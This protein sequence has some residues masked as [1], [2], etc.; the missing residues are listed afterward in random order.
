MRLFLSILFTALALSASAQTT[1]DV[2]LPVKSDSGPLTPVWITKTAGKVIGWDGSGVLGPITVSGGAWGS[3]TGTLSAQTD[4]QSALDAKLSTSSAASTYQ[5]LASNLTTLSAG[6]GAGN[7][8]VTWDGAAFVKQTSPLSVSLG[9][10]GI[11]SFGTGIAA[12]LGVNIGSAGA[13][14]LFNGAAGTPTSIVLTNATGSP[15]GISLTKTQ[16]NTIVS[17]DDPAYISTA[18]TFTQAQTFSRNG[19]ASVSAISLTGTPFSGGTGTTTFPLLSLIPASGA[20]TVTNWSVNGTALGLVLPDANTNGNFMSL[21]RSNTI[22]ADITSTGRMRG[23]EASILGA[24]GLQCYT[25]QTLSVSEN[26]SGRAILLGGVASGLRMASGYS[27]N[28]SSS[29]AGSG[30][31]F[32]NLDVGLARNSAGV[33]RVSNGSSGL[34]ALSTGTLTVGTNGTGIVQIRRYSLT[35]VAG[36]VTQADTA[37]TANSTIIVD[38]RTVGGTVGDFNTSIS[39]GSSFTIN[40]SSSSETSTV[41]ATVIIFP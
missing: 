8:L 36:T 6:F 24:S 7:G 32:S 15:T 21:I 38:R 4:L 23:F 2:Q 14:V 41:T 5:P 9:G 39:A 29:A 37:I 33:L 12:A 40:S 3:I 35:L 16:L 1:G 31:S 20:T 19:A 13:P 18:Q 34:G 10:T 11:S 22:I 17:D 28:W 27:I 25:T 30:D 26:T